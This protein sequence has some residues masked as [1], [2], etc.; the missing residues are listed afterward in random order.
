MPL[1]I[2][3]VFALCAAWAAGASAQSVEIRVKTG[4]RTFVRTQEVFADKAPIY[5]GPVEGEG[6]RGSLK[7]YFQA[8]LDRGTDLQFNLELENAEG[9][10]M[11]VVNT[12]ALVDG[13]PVSPVKCGPFDVQLTLKGPPKAKPAKPTANAKLTA[14]VLADD[15]SAR[16][17]FTG[18]SV[19]RIEADVDLRVGERRRRLK[20]DAFPSDI[21]REKSTLSGF[22]ELSGGGLTRLT[23]LRPAGPFPVDKKVVVLEGGGTRVLLRRDSK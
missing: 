23:A 6:G 11:R 10:R 17:V 4:G 13:A 16:C 5:D 20:V 3:A 15:G 9:M 19:H 1:K 12:L 8:V 22:F 18:G 21:T 14:E 7:M 2:A